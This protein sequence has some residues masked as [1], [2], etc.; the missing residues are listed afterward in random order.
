MLK[1]SHCFDIIVTMS[2]Y[3]IIHIYP[4]LQYVSFLF[5]AKLKCCNMKALKVIFLLLIICIWM[6][7][8][9][10]KEKSAKKGKKKGKQVDCPS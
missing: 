2:V 1:Y 6:E 10:T 3:N 8:G 4:F 7:V 5:Q 9:F